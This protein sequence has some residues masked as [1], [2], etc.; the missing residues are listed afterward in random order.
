MKYRLYFN[1][2]DDA[3]RIWSYDNGSGTKEVIVEDVELIN[4][5]GRFCFDGTKHLP[6]PSAWLEVIGILE[7]C[8]GR[9][10]IRGSKEI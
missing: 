8:N 1:C 3:P 7:N 9:I 6:E 4:C 10:T 2:R 5:T